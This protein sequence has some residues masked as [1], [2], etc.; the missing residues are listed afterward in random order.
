MPGY[1]GAPPRNRA[2]GFPAHGSSN[3]LTRTG[4]S[5]QEPQGH[6]AGP[7]SA[8]H[9]WPD[10][11]LIRRPLSSTGLSPASRVLWTDPTS[12]R[13]SP[14]LWL[15]LGSASTGCPCGDGRISRVPCASRP[16]VPTAE[17]PVDA[18]PLSPGRAPAT[19]FP[20]VAYGSASTVFGISGLVPFTPACV[21]GFRPTEF[22]STLRLGS[23]PPAGARLGPSTKR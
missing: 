22:L 15:P 1:P 12:R 4:S 5:R 17:A 18:R 11:T 8:R 20:A 13:H 7:L 14:P 16:C 21:C 23:Y 10:D 3:Q 6:G 19:A 2:C 9:A